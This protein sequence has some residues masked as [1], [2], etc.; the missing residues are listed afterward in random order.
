[1]PAKNVNIMLCSI[2]SARE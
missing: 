1:M 2:E